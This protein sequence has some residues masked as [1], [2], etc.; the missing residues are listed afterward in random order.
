MHRYKLSSWFALTSVFVIGAAAIAVNFVVGNLAERNL[1][2]IAEENTARDA[3]H[4]NAMIR[5]HLKS[6]LQA[7]GGN[8][9]EQETLSL[10]FLEGPSGLSMILPSL[11]E[12][13]S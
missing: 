11:V 7:T 13:L 1:V 2:R 6:T 12:G 5:R 8:N 3:D 9:A 4:L 10:E